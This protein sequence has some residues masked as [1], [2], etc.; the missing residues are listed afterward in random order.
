MPSNTRQLDQRSGGG[1]G[2]AGDVTRRIVIGVSSFRWP[3]YTRRM[4]DLFHALFRALVRT[5]AHRP[6][7]RLGRREEDHGAAAALPAQ[8]RL[9]RRDPAGQSGAQR[10]H[11]RQG[12]QDPRRHPGRDRSRLHPAERQGCG[13][14]PRGLRQAWRE[15]G[16]DPGRRLCRCGRRGRLAAGRSGAH[17]ARDRHPAGR[18]QQHR[19]RQHRSADGAHR[20]CRLRRRQIARRQLGAGEPERQPDRRPAV[21]RRRPRHRLLAPDLGR[22]RG[23]PRGG[24]DRRPA[25][26]RSQDPR[27][28]AVHGDPA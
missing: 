10:D 12:L 1:S 9:C 13:R 19:H 7:R 26:R 14:S 25:G 24:R 22:Q 18:T 4:N 28:P 15:S 3:Q 21:A 17:R 20:Q 16:V 5:P 23:R 11:G 6:D 2:T 27:D 8:A